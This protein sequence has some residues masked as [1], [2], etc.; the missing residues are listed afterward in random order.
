MA[1]SPNRS[2]RHL[3]NGK[4]GRG[5]AYGSS[6]F[7]ELSVLIN[8]TDGCQLSRSFMPHILRHNVCASGV[9]RGMVELSNIK[10][11]KE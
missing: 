4:W 6:F 10:K 9:E 2:R 8:Q 11:K 1:Y 3:D 7:I 5:V